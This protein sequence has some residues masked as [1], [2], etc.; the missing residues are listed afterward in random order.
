M[1]MLKDAPGGPELI[2]VLIGA[3]LNLSLFFA[4]EP[5]DKVSVALEETR[6]NLKAG[7]REIIGRNA[8]AALADAFVKA[9]MDR[10]AE[11]ESRSRFPSTTIG[12]RS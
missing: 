1:T 12:L 9:V 5:D 2:Q 3:A 7:L 4:G 11:I 10:R 8:G 6:E